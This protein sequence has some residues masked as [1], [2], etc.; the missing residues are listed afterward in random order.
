MRATSRGHVTLRSAN[1]YEHPAIQFNYLSTEEDRADMRECVKLTREM[2]A[3]K[4]FDPYR[5]PEIQ[6]GQ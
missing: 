5:G 6:P 3:Q 4:A 1:P 2:F